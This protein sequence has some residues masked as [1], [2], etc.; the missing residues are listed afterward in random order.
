MI[1]ERGRVNMVKRI[2]LSSKSLKFLCRRAM[3]M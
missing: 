3:P 1:M 2:T